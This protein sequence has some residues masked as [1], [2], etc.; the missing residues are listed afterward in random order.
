MSSDTGPFDEIE[1]VFDRLSRQFEE[2]EPVEFGHGSGR[3]PVDLHDESEEFV[4]VADLAGYESEDVEVTLADERRIEISAERETD[5]ERDEDGVYVRRER[6]ESVS[7]TVSLPDPVDES[8]TSATFDDG[9]LT[10][11]LRKRAPE[12]GDSHS[13]P[14]N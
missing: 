4:L 1:R 7:R 14:V 6:R 2:L 12:D 5:S 3:L 9:V 10:V 13:I 8:E 11:T